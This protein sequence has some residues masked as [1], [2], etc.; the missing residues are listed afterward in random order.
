[1]SYVRI[2]RDGYSLNKVDAEKIE[3]SLAGAPDDLQA[4]TKLLGFYS[5]AA[6]GFMEPK[7]PSHIGAGISYGLIEHQPASE[8]VGLSEATIDPAGHIPG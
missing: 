1:V 8:S 6:S 3:A 5:E 4:R 7:P 2:A